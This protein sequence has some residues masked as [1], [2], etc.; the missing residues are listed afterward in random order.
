MSVLK[1]IYLSQ[2]ASNPINTI[3]PS[4]SVE[5]NTIP[6]APVKNDRENISTTQRETNPVSTK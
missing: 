3:A 2:R 5:E 1:Q 4:S 6:N